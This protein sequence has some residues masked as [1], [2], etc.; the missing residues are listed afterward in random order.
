MELR[1]DQALHCSA[2]A[3]IDLPVEDWSEVEKWYIK[4]DT[5]HY[6]LKGEEDWREIDLNSMGTDCVEW[7]R[8]LSAEVYGVSDEGE[9]WLDET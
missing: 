6:L 7:K 4:W 1:I 2:I 9:T 3:Y 8:P 5:L